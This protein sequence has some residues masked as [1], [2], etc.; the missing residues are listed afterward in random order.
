MTDR[1]ASLKIL[2]GLLQKHRKRTVQY[3]DAQIGRRIVLKIAEVYQNYE[4]PNADTEVKECINEAAA[5]LEE[6]QY[7]SVE[8]MPFSDDITKLYLRQENMPAI[9]QY[10][11]EHFG[12][13]SRSRMAE[14]ITKLI[15][16]YA[17]QGVLTAC[18]CDGLA[19]RIKALSSALDVG[20]ERDILRVLAFIQN[21]EKDIYIREV[22]VLVYGDS[23]IL[24]QKYLNVVCNIIRDAEGGLC[25][26][27]GR[28]AETLQKYHIWSMEQE[29]CI[30]GDFH[31]EIA[32]G[33][34]ETK[35]LRGGVSLSS[36]DIGQ[37]ERVLVQTGNLVTIE[38]KTSYHRF[39]EENFS[40]VYLGGYASHCQIEFLKKV[41]KDNPHCRFWHFG[42]IDI[43]GFLIHQH[44]CGATGIPFEL[45]H[46]SKKELNDPR[47]AKALKQLTDNDISRA[48]GLKSNLYYGETVKEILRKNIKL[49]QEIISY[50]LYT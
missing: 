44:L 35:R 7:I 20:R 24:E 26:E 25:I 34:I 41:Y 32:G 5:A 50:S 18:Y 49:E 45:W 38:N 16:E 23:K 31:I 43:G 17:G 42:D 2:N 48:Q 28:N 13:A 4:R 6:L 37:I 15:R 47:Y 9:E 27:D 8:R 40:M 39:G 46:M 11:E 12:E 29:I 14:D 22:S 19:E 3:G 33:A 36:K 1:E 10:L 30:R 21:N